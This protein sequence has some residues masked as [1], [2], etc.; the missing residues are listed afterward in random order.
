MHMH[1]YTRRDV[2]H[3]HA[4]GITCTRT[5]IRGSHIEIWELEIVDHARTLRFVYLDPE[6]IARPHRD[7]G[8]ERSAF[9]GIRI[10]GCPTHLAA[11][12]GFCGGGESGGGCP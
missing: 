12:L 9:I 5:H 8:R 11:T 1:T 6:W 2:D 3:A 4:S 10:I 7:L